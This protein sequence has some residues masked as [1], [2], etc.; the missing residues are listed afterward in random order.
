[1]SLAPKKVAPATRASKPIHEVI[2]GLQEHLEE[3][4]VWITKYK[5][6]SQRTKEFNQELSDFS[7]L[8]AQSTETMNDSLSLVHDIYG[9]MNGLYSAHQMNR[10]CRTGNPITKEIVD[11]MKETHFNMSGDSPKQSLEAILEKNFECDET[12]KTTKQNPSHPK[13]DETSAKTDTN[14]H[15]QS[16]SSGPQSTQSNDREIGKIGF[17]IS[18]I[19]NLSTLGDLLLTTSEDGLSHVVSISGIDQFSPTIKSEPTKQLSVRTLQMFTNKPASS[20]PSSDPSPSPDP[21]YLIQQLTTTSLIIPLLHKDGDPSFIMVGTVTG[22]IHV[23]AYPPQPSISNSFRSPMYRF[24]ITSHQAPIIAL[25]YFIQILTQSQPPHPKQQSHP[26]RV[27]QPPPQR[28]C[29]LILTASM[30][31]TFHLWDFGEM[32]TATQSGNRDSP[33]DTIGNIEYQNCK[34]QPRFTFRSSTLGMIYTACII[35][36][37]RL[38]VLL[39]GEMGLLYFVCVGNSTSSLSKDTPSATALVPKDTKPPGPLK[40]RHP[41]L[42]LLANPTHTEID[43]LTNFSV[44]RIETLKT[45]NGA[46]RPV[47]RGEWTL[48]NVHQAKENNDCFFVAMGSFRTLI[49]VGDNKGCT[50]VFNVL[51]AK[52]KEGSSEPT[53]I[54]GL[55]PTN[56][57][58]KPV[59]ALTFHTK[60]PILM[61]GNEMGV[62]SFLSMIG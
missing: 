22:K 62:I 59:T 11:A 50:K 31:G 14:D 28:I 45:E 37:D 40:A 48:V 43:I 17:H 55:Q 32:Q 36:T 27:Q 6:E 15:K 42:K 24:T 41:I 3:G 29:G 49:A 7:A 13:T 20:T 9:R 38:G 12:H 58:S 54:F 4:A 8:T 60:R 61:V 33:E 5:Y 51:V 57:P 25:D 23:F 10:Y 34:I 46:R 19:V 30:D 35:R 2:R 56:L 39:G 52:K 18:S 44:E 47:A 26:G 21:S 16:E 1:M 53:S